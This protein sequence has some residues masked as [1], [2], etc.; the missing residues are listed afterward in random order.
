MDE[1]LLKDLLATAIANNYNWDII[2]PKFPELKDVD[3]QLLKDYAATAE[4]YNYDYSII[5]PKFPEF[6]GDDVKKKRRI[7]I[8]C[9]RGRY[10]ICY[11]RRAGSYWLIGIFRSRS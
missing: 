1:Q 4:A 6:F 8:Y 7:S 10:G 9:G 2:M 11:R 5:N 3:V